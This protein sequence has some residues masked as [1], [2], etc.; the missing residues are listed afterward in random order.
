MWFHLIEILTKL[1]KNS[2]Y[3][4]LC[5]NWFYV[6]NIYLV[7]SHLY[8]THKKLKTH[9]RNRWNYCKWNKFQSRTQSNKSIKKEFC[10]HNFRN[11]L[12]VHTT[13][14]FNLLLVFYLCFCTIIFKWW[15][16]FTYFNGILFIWIITIITLG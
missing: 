8:C 9:Y 6:I 10:I 3:L 15:Q 7:I 16:L 2:I 11:F 4:M 13:S 1:K 12:Q 14:N 5:S